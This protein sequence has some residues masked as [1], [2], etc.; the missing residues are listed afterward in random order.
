MHDLAFLYEM[1]LNSY[2][3]FK[4]CISFLSVVEYISI[5]IC[6]IDLNRLF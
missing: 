3:Y 6:V 5:C 1:L 2:T 4:K